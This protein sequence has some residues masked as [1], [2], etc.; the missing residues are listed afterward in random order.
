[1][2]TEFFSV[3]TEWTIRRSC[4]TYSD[5]DNDFQVNDGDDIIGG[6][7]R[8]ACASDLCNSVDGTL[9][10]VLPKKTLSSAATGN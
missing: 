3:T 5:T 4:K 6:T 2:V 9:L 1:M 8:L 7:A 10:S